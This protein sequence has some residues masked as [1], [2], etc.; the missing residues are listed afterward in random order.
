MDQQA[1]KFK[2]PRVELV[3]GDSPFIQLL[4]AGLQSLPLALQISGLWALP[5]RL[6]LS[7]FG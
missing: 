4:I 2:L 7:L 6:L 3:D 1:P 5:T